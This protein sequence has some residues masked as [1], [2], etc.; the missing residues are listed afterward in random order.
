MLTT[1][2]EDGIEAARLDYVDPRHKLKLDG[3]IAGFNAC[4]DKSIEE[5]TSLL[6][7]SEKKCRYWRCYHLEVEWT[8]NVISAALRNQ[9]EKVIITPTVR[10]MSKAIE[11]LGVRT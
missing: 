11:I 3:S 2:I 9:N 1:I 7:E 8:C 5:L 10:G 6:H 4:R